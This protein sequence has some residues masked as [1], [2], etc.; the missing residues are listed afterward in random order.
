[1]SWRSRA[2]HPG[3]VIALVCSQCGSQEFA[4]ERDAVLHADVVE[5]CDGELLLAGPSVAQP[6][7]DACLACS[8][9]GAELEGIEWDTERPLHVPEGRSPLEDAKALDALAA[10]LNKPGQWNGADICELAADLLRRTGR[11]IEDEPYPED[12]PG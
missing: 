4:Y 10:E 12:R 5:I 1:M 6:L 7:D 8:A 11:R 3:A 2:E 9:C